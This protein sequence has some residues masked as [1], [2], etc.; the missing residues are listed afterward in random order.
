MADGA[1]ERG[2][3]C[4]HGADG[5][6]GAERVRTVE[7]TGG[8]GPRGADTRTGR[9]GTNGAHEAW[10]GPSTHGRADKQTGGRAERESGGRADGWTGGLGWIRAN[11]QSAGRADEQVGLGLKG[12]IPQGW[13]HSWAP[14]PLASSERECVGCLGVQWNPVRFHVKHPYLAP[15]LTC[16]VLV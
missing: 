3:R 13:V 9:R 8:W 11:G 7:R 10:T 2:G 4:V 15:G 6:M 1:G 16:L 5:R 14:S 12:H